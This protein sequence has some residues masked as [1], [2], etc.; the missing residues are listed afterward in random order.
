MTEILFIVEEAKERGYV[1]RAV[2]G[3]IVTEADDL[4]Q[5]RT[6][7]REAVRCHYEEANVERPKA[8]RLYLV[9]DESSGREGRRRDHGG[10]LPSRLP[11]STRRISA[12]SSRF[13]WLPDGLWM[14]R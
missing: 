5:L 8:I 6:M 11:T 1:A 3:P 13:S 9:R 4:A 12:Y 14:C 2:G 7:V 10:S